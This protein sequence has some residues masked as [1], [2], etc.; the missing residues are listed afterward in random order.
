MFVVV[1][2]LFFLILSISGLAINGRGGSL[3][4][5]EDQHLG[6]VDVVGTACN[7]DHSLCN[8]ITVQ[9]HK[10]LVDRVGLFLI[11]TETN[12]RELCLDKTY[13]QVH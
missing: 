6:N 7:K 8:I 4:G 5:R 9:W 13:D 3:V 11:T 2:A 10:S 1:G 12:H